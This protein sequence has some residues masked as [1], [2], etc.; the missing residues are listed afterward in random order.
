MRCLTPYDPAMRLRTSLVVLVLCLVGAA[1]VTRA[2]VTPAV[3]EVAG[4]PGAPVLVEVRVGASTAIGAVE[5]IDPDAP[6]ART[7]AARLLWPVLPA[8]S[9]DALLRW[10]SPANPLRF[11]DTRPSGDGLSPP[12]TA[13][14]AVELPDELSVERRSASRRADGRVVELRIGAA[15]VALR[16]YAPASGDLLDRLA[17]R[18]SMLVPQGARS[19]LLSLPDPLA[20][21]E[22]FRIALGAAMRGWPQPMPFGDESGDDLASRAHTA[23][24]LAALSRAMSAGPGPAVELA[25]LLV[26]TCTEPTAPAPIA[27]WI[28]GDEEL[29]TALKLMLEPEFSGERLAA[30]VNEFV[31]VR[32]P[33]LW[34]ID[35]SDRESVTFAFANPTTR[36]Q[37]VRYHWV[38]G[39]EEDMLPLVLEVPPTEV[40]RTRVTRPTIERPRFMTGEPEAIER[41]R[42][43]CGGSDRSVLVPPAI[44]PVGAGG[45]ELREFFAPLHLAAIS[46]GA[47]VAPSIATSTTIALRER[48]QG[49]EVFAEIRPS[50]GG[51]AE[52]MPDALRAIGGAGWVQVDAVAGIT[53]EGCDIPQESLAFAAYSDRARGAFFVPPE[54]IARERA[55]IVVRAGF[56]R[57][58]PGGFVD[59][60]FPSVPWRAQP[61][62]AAF[63]LT[64]RQ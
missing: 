8:P 35:D 32:P 48:L 59:A 39:S 64:P 27:A 44:V 36:P 9:G 18:A 22:R 28:A 7:L 40:R 50:P 24:W 60:P 30:S 21:F 42:I 45:L 52:T 56:R 26:A 20:P 53:A 55:A 33:V 62:S 58:L 3:R 1:G 37:I 47:R 2:Q 5:L 46:P 31:R 16:L 41:L 25:E 23:L 29:G 15:R 13:Y 10:A 17:A 11:V 43:A 6:R 51:G 61:R 12:A 4:V 38:I 14:L 54:W 57:T 49:W 19:E 34:W 63:D